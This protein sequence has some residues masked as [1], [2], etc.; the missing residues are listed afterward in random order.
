MV[1]RLP[2][3]LAALVAV[4]AIALP[5][6]VVSPVDAVS[7][8]GDSST[9]GDV[10]PVRDVAA[11]RT[12]DI[13]PGSVGRTSLVL[14]ATY[15]TYLKISWGPRSIWVDSTATIRNTSGGPIDRIE[16]NTIAARLGTI[17]LR[18]VTVDGAVVAATISDQTIVVPLGGILPVD[19]VTKVRVRFGATVRSSL[20]GSNWLF[21]RTNGIL[22]L[23]RWLPWV[24]RKIAFSRPNHGDPFETPSSR[25]VKVRIVSSRRLVLATS[26][27]RTGISADG[28]TQ[29]FTASNVR[30]FTV[31]AAPDYRTKS[32]VVGGT[33]VRVYYR[34]GAPGAA[35][36]DAA[37]DAFAALRARLGAYPYP[38]FKVVQSAG[39]YGM[40]SPRLIWIPTGVATSNL[41]YLAA[42]ETAHQWFYG[43]V[44]NDQAF[45]PFTD[46]AAA[47]FVARYVLGLKRGSR[48]TTG[49]LDLR[50]Y[51]YSSSCYY[52]RIY[53]Q[54]GNL[55]DTARRRM[56]STAFWAALRG[57][58]T[59]NRYRIATTSSLLEALDAATPLDLGGTLF[60][61]R[62]PRIY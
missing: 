52:E 16:L 17:R 6:P 22:D 33:T 14:D 36:L 20:T 58:V 51:D 30:D 61:P 7:R 44:G 19:G 62:F 4:G 25:S 13:V 9:T 53:I 31:T 28:L 55:L 43:L 60:G 21:T 26:G 15:D 24:S 47:D 34:P 57:Y 29:T 35:M 32:R 45:E 1:R 46:E 59:A 39:G 12:G 40:E 11:A 8:E 54:G 49:R 3:I 27:D 38:T 48:C 42:H 56:G 37:A 10:A 50:I 2:L 23:Y 41:R 5:S 18:P